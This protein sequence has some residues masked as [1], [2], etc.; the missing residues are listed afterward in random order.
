[1]QQ[2]LYMAELDKI[3]KEQEDE[4]PK[5][6][7]KYKKLDSLFEKMKSKTEEQRMTL[8]NDMKSTKGKGNEK[9]D[10]STKGYILPKS[11]K[12]DEPAWLTDMVHKMLKSWKFI[13]DEGYSCESCGQSFSIMTHFESHVK[14]KHTDYKPFSCHICSYAARGKCLATD[15]LKL[16]HN[17][18]LS[19]L[20]DKSEDGKPSNLGTKALSQDDIITKKLEQLWM[21]T[22]EGSKG[23][24]DCE[25]CRKEETLFTSIKPAAFEDHIKKN[26][27]GYKPFTCNVC[28]F[29]ANRRT[30]LTTHV[31]KFHFQMLSNLT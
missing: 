18:S 15:H 27:P 23:I 11:L 8:E 10:G 28:P 5:S 3:K 21:F 19:N 14:K 24:Y 31:K 17:P 26:H 25:A 2:E 13:R 12:D 22:K 4:A 30:N 16:K 1:M 7:E 6:W 29:S 20:A 9:S